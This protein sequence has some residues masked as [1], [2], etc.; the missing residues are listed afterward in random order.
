MAPSRNSTLVTKPPT[1]AR[2]WTSSTASKR[3]VNSSQSVTVRFT[4]C[5]TVTG[6][7]AAAGCCGGL[8]PQPDSA[9]A[10]TGISHARPRSEGK[11]ACAGSAGRFNGSVAVNPHLPCTLDIP[12]RRNGCRGTSWR[13][14]Q[15]CS[16]PS[17]VKKAQRSS[18]IVMHGAALAQCANAKPC[19]AIVIDRPVACQG[20]SRWQSRSRKIASR[21]DEKVTPPL[22]ATRAI[23]IDGW[24]YNPNRFILP[25]RRSNA[26]PSLRAERSEAIHLSPRLQS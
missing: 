16:V 12:D 24:G 19:V 5:A 23:R 9:S 13:R 20:G 10:S 25:E 7:A 6:G 18:T 2:T 1:R 26:Q 3:P 14:P 4:G 15:M 21:H 11:P 17:L 22:R 8:S